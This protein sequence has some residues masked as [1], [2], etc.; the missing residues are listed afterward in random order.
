[1]GAQR[2]RV[3]EALCRL[4]KVGLLTPWRRELNGSEACCFSSR[5][6]DFLPPRLPGVRAEEHVS[7]PFH[8]LAC[9]II[10]SPGCHRW[11]THFLRGREHF[12]YVFGVPTRPCPGACARYTAS[13]QRL[14]RCFNR[15]ADSPT[16][17]TRP[18]GPSS[19]QRLAA[20][21]FFSFLFLEQETQPDQGHRK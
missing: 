12:P 2:Q 11:E 9:S 6:E 20:L 1:M 16:Q 14:H 3:W 5:N 4:G 21:G 7:G 18:S 15:Q 8:P 19:S 10:V 17:M 13:T